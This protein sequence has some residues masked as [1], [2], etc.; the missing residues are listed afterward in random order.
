MY[1]NGAFKNPFA[2]FDFS[3][4]AG[5]FKLPTVNVETFVETARKNF[6]TMTSLNTA[7]VE[8]MK[9]IAQRQ[10][11]MVRAAMEDFSKHGSE[12]L[13]AATVEEKAAKQIDFI[14]KSYDSAITNTKELADLYTKGQADAVTALSARVAELTEEVKAAIA[15][16]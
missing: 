3:K 1:A 13:A 12:V 14:K 11:D 15:K 10:G 16:K 2:D 7:A 8:Q 5:E 9:T 6:A 4:V